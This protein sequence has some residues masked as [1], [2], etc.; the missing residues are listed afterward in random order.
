MGTSTAERGLRHGVQSA[1]SPS[2]AQVK[3]PVAYRA[4]K[5]PPRKAV[6]GVRVVLGVLGG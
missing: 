3:V 5:R 2:E 4:A 1:P 6:A